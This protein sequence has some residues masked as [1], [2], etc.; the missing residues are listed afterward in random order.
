MGWGGNFSLV[1]PILFF[2]LVILFYYDKDRVSAGF[3][4]SYKC[5]YYSY[6]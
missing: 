1:H 4:Y 3:V 5:S 2:Q 6:D